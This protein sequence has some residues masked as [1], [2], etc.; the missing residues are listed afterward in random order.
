MAKEAVPNVVGIPPAHEAVDCAL[1][2][3]PDVYR[4]PTEVSKT[5]ESH[6]VFPEITGTGLESATVC[7]PAAVLTVVEAD[8]PRRL[9]GA[10]EASE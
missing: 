9:V 2:G 8:T 10:P 3:V 5:H 4:V 1:A 6:T 7:Q